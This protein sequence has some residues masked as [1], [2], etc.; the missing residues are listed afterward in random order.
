LDTI[1][2]QCSMTSNDQ[3]KC[4]ANIVEYIFH[5]YVFIKGSNVWRTKIRP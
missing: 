5:G 3:A 4:K 2:L 1:F